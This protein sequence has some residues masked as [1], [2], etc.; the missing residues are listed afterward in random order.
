M[1]SV[2]K[3]IEKLPWASSGTPR[4]WLPAAAPKRNGQRKVGERENE[5]PKPLPETVVD[6]STNFNR[7]AAQN[8]TPQDEHQGEIVA[9]KSRRHQA[10]EYRNQGATEADQPHFVPRP[11][12]PDRGN[13]LPSLIG[14]SCHK[15]LQHSGA[16]IPPIQHHIEDKHETDDGVPCRNHTN[17]SFPLTGSCSAPR[18]PSSGRSATSSPSGPR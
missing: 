7:N 16:K 18:T 12:R 5:V 17:D 8:Q 14:R 11:Q 15:S 1:K 4:T 9:G 13:H 2:K 3:A 10:R 6:V